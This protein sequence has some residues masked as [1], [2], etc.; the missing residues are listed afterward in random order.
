VT[1]GVRLILGG[2]YTPPTGS[3]RLVLQADALVLPG[4]PINGP[5]VSVPWEAGEEAG[6][7]STRF[8][9]AQNSNTAHSP[10]T[11][12]AWGRSSNLPAGVSL[13][14]GLSGALGV[15]SALK[16]G[17][18]IGVSNTVSLPWERTLS[19]T[20]GAGLP[21]ER[22]PMQ[23]IARGLSWGTAGFMSRLGTL[24]WGRADGL[25]ATNTYLPP[26]VPP[27]PSP[28][29]S[30]L[31]LRFCKPLLPN[32]LTLVLGVDPCAGISYPATTTVITDRTTYMS[33][34]SLSIVKMPGATALSVH[35][36]QLTTDESSFGW[37]LSFEGNESLLTSLAPVS[38]VPTAIRATI[39]GL[40][41]DLVVQNL[42]RNRSFGKVTA[43]VTAR[44]KSVLLASPYFPTLT[45]LNSVPMT[46]QQAVLDALAFTGVGLDWQVTDWLLP[47]GAWSHTG[48]ALSAVRRIAD[49]IGAVVESPRTGSTLTVRPR[50]PV[51]PWNI[52]SATP[53]VVLT[54]LGA[55]SMEG[56]ERIDTPEY[57]GVHVSGQAYGDTL[58]LV[59]ITGSGPSLILPLVTDGL[60][61][62]VDAARQRG[63]SLLGPSGSHALMSLTLPVLTG[64]GEPGIIGPGKIIQ[65]TDG[66]TTWRGI[67]RSVSVSGTFEQ[68]SQTVSIDRKL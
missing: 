43:S 19:V 55:V 59:R 51:M 57:D 38:G 21:W 6:S 36:L 67:S 37:N 13:P 4:T 52:G 9:W 34:V 47:A 14:W 41:F 26:Y 65:V 58:A 32:R 2:S 7:S 42:R 29:L 30:R 28:V 12:L 53:D 27:P 8:P 39:N 16:W 40:V 18:T 62:H 66:A 50:Y 61:T 60:I 23:S 49:A 35:S 54:S 44:S 64:V 3:V 10:P 22:S 1:S 11:S 68:L 5:S 31:R 17:R 33:Q 15:G 48:T 24:P 25:I 56:Y 46:A 63:E 20:Y 45:F